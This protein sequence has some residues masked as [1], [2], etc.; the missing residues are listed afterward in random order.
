MSSVSSLADATS[1]GAGEEMS[2]IS[3]AHSATGTTAKDD[4][5]LRH[6]L[7]MK[8]SEAKR[9]QDSVLH[10]SGIATSKDEALSVERARSA[11]LALALKDAQAV[12]AARESDC[13][14]LKRDHRIA[15]QQGASL[16]SELQT[17]LGTCSGLESQVTQ[18]GER[19]LLYLRLVCRV[20]STVC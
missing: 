3:T 12:A 9:W 4:S 2:F 6:Q 15:L 19:S 10:L 1:S 18:L 7:W 20:F 11:Q 5:T 8:T 16:Q 13:E 17:I 14:Q